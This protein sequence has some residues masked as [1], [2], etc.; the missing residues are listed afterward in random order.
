MHDQTVQ[1]AP[2]TE[3]SI[4]LIM[5]FNLKLVAR[6]L[7]HMFFLVGSFVFL[8][9]TWLLTKIVT[10]AQSNYIKIPK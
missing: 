8:Y 10:L 1:I 7:F 3:C 4:I 9:H 5:G 2:E 6:Q